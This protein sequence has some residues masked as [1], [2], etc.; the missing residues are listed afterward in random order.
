MM[1][2]ALDLTIFSAN[3][4]A[5]SLYLLPTSV[6]TKTTDLIFRLS[7]RV[8]VFS[9]AVIGVDIS[10]VTAAFLSKGSRLPFDD[11]PLR[12]NSCN[13]LNTSPLMVKVK[14]Q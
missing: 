3:P 1:H 7:L 2:V 8:A 11:H 10:M 5:M 12:S 14:K 13:V 4:L 6:H 9:I